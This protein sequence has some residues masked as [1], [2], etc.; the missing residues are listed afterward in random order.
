VARSR[1]VAAEE[2][3]LP[4]AILGSWASNCN[5]DIPHRLSFGPTSV[6]VVR[7]ASPLTCHRKG[8]RSLSEARWYVDLECNDGSPLQL[9]LYL[10]T[11][12]SL[13]VAQRP[14]GEA[15]RYRRL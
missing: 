2:P 14:L 5:V 10:V 7:G 3:S 9:D 13:L 4:P 12:M 15:C 6:E 8:H 11:R 1:K